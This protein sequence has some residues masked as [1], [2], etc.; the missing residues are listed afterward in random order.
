L[1]G[2]VTVRGQERAHPP[3]PSTPRRQITDPCNK[4]IRTGNTTMVT[5][6]WDTSSECRFVIVRYSL[7]YNSSWGAKPVAEA[8]RAYSF[9]EKPRLLPFGFTAT[10]R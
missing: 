4:A 3:I 6:N 7:I 9:V 10:Y 8:G 1:N 2:T 5:P